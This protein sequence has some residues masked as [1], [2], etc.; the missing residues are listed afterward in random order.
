MSD[1]PYEPGFENTK[2]SYDAA[3]TVNASKLHQLVLALHRQAGW[4]GLTDAELDA[5][6]PKGCPT[7]RPRR[8]E[9]YRQGMLVDTEMRRPSPTTKRAM[10]VWGLPT[11]RT[12]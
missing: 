4:A 12:Q 6:R 5:N 7:L 3:Q 8:I 2:T 9:L 10:I 11:A 1:Y